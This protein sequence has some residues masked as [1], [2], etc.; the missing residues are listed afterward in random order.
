MKRAMK[1]VEAGRFLTTSASLMITM[2]MFLFMASHSLAERELKDYCVLSVGDLNADGVEDYA[3]GEHPAVRGQAAT[4]YVIF[5]GGGSLPDHIDGTFLKKRADFILRGSSAAPFSCNRRPGSQAAAAV[6]KD[7]GARESGSRVAA[8][9][10]GESPVG[11][12]VFYTIGIDLKP[13]NPGN[14][15]IAAG[16]SEDGQVVGHSWAPPGF[17]HAF[18]YDGKELRDLGTLG[19]HYSYARA[20]NGDGDIVGHSNNGETDELGFVNY[21]FISNIY[22]MRDLG[23]RWSAASDIND[24][25]QIVGEMQVV[26]GRY[27][28]FIYEEGEATDL[29]TLDGEQSFAMAVNE[30][31]QVVGEACTFGAGTLPGNV[32]HSD[33]AF[34][35]E[36]GTI[37][38]LGSL[39]Y[40]C[41]VENDEGYLEEHCYERSSAT[42]INDRGQIV[43]F[44]STFDSGTHAFRITGEA[45]ED[46][47]TLG[48]SQSWAYAVNDSGQV[49]GTSIS[50]TDNFYHPFLY[51]LGV[52]YDL[53]ELVLDRPG[54]FSMWEAVD[55]NNFG[56]IVGLGY[57]LEPVYEVISRGKVIGFSD[58]LGPKLT[59]EYWGSIAETERCVEHGQTSWI[60][61]R[62]ETHAPGSR[63]LLTSDLSRWHPIEDSGLGC[64]E[65]EDWRTAYIPVPLGLEDTEL[66]VRIRLRNAG[67]V[68]P[69]VYLRHF[70]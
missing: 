70:R 11:R 45:F 41:I 10:D 68:N 61:Y 27:H 67:G 22:G 8:W 36:D 25:G 2:F 37:F 62:L 16:I 39:G 55:I 30:T 4:A 28:A 54:D 38:D 42:D 58:I 24:R 66:T 12:P 47:G 40:E 46:L 23:L 6:A 9:R 3:V 34:L 15:V 48:G 19:G 52:M 57:L 13:L 5:G 43:G 51:D 32:F 60:E 59:F 50:G 26:P 69:V 21:A 29:G 64:S 17:D 20:V 44:S 53:R 65:S 31:G 49:V 35:Y 7:I 63:P 18:L 14:Y 56:Q 1:R 33:H